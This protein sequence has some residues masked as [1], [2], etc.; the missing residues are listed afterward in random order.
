MRARDGRGGPRYET[1]THQAPRQAEPHS[2]RPA[3]EIWRDGF[4]YGFRDALRLAARELPPECWPVL[5]ELANEYELA[6]GDAA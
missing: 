5:H 2:R 1:A 3:G 4:A 6:G